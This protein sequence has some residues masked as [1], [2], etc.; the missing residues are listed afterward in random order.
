MPDSS[1]SVPEPAKPEKDFS[2]DAQ[3]Q[4]TGFGEK[5]ERKFL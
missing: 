2:F 1:D 4:F 3:Q 5:R